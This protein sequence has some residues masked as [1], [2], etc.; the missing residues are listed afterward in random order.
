MAQ[1][2][3]AAPS[4]D[5]HQVSTT[6]TG[7]SITNVVFVAGKLYVVRI[8]ISSNS[9]TA[10]VSDSG[11]TWTRQVEQWVTGT[12]WPKIEI[13]T[14]VGVAGTRNVNVSFG[15]STEHFVE[16]SELSNTDATT[17]IYGSGSNA[18]SSAGLSHQLTSTISAPNKSLALGVMLWNSTPG[19]VTATGLTTGWNVGAGG[20]TN[21]M[22]MYSRTIATA[23]SFTGPITTT[24]SRTSAG[25]A[26]VLQPT[27]AG[28]VSL[29]GQLLLL[30]VGA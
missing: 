3:F 18:V 7:S 29:A 24:S 23:E 16:I 6:A 10:T 11:N 19:T 15:F 28:G 17:P 9:R 20:G 26:I 1:V 2:T 4:C 8:A 27:I 13:W 21:N 14:C 30:G 25:G 22:R 12:T 5:E